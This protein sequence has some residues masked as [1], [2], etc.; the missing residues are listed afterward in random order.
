MTQSPLAS[1]RLVLLSAAGALLAAHTPARA[2][3]LAT[4]FSRHSG[5]SSKTV[6]HSAWSR[7]LGLHV[8]PD[9]RGINRI[10]YAA[11]KARDHAGLRSYVKS[12]EAVDVATLDRPEQFAFWANLYNA[13]TIDIV[14]EHY[15]VKS[16]RNINLGGGLKSLVTGGPWQA[17][18]LTVGGQRLSLDDI[19]N[20]IMR[21]ILKDPR[22][23]Y[24]INCA[25]IGCPNLSLSAFTGARLDEM[26]DANA[27][28][29]INH[30]R[31]FQ[32]DGDRI[33]A[34]SIYDWFRSD[35]G[36]SVAG[37]LAHARAYAGP[38]LKARL[39]GRTAIER[40]EYDW[41]LADASRTQ[42]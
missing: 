14:L 31:G 27:R 30:P 24:S 22:V 29:Y 42:S 32:V 35:F 40:Y 12:L 25:S 38:E 34:S 18:V 36:G 17:S 13:K 10:D 26:L 39:A 15:P 11:W 8:K 28:A 3:A 19:E 6:D 33:T 2:G 37:V 23:H 1:R 4:T 9:A 5:G 16:I 7:L 21:P 20:E 41:D